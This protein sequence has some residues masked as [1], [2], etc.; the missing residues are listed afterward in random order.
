MKHIIVELSHPPFGHEHTFAGLYVATASLSKAMDVTVLLRG[1]AVYTAMKGQVEPQRLIALPPTEQQ[2][3]DILALGGRV[4]AEA[5]SMEVRGLGPEELVEGIEV[6][7]T[8]EIHDLL[9][10]EGDHVVAF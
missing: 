10:N 9:L 5:H 2:V 7:S 1:D 3:E 4:I 6:L 8:Q